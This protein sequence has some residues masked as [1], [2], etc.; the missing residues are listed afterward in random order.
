ML[1]ISGIGYKS[2]EVTPGNRTA[3]DVTLA[4]DA[5]VL[6]EVIVTGYTTDSW[7]DNTGAVGTVK[8]KDLTAVPSGNVEQQLQ[9]RVAGVTVITNGQPGTSSI[10]RAR[11]FGAFGGNEP[12]YVVDGVP[13]GDVGFVNPNDVETTTV[14]KDAASASI[15]GARAANGVIVMT[16]N[17][18][19]RKGQGITV[20]YDGLAGFTDPGVAPTAHTTITT[21]TGFST[22]T[23][24]TALTSAMAKGR[25]IT[26][27]GRLPTRRST[28]KRLVGTPLTCWGVFKH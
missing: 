28:A 7:R 4:E 20:T 13:T 5:S 3:V 11:G 8:A 12:L 14:L 15:C 19:T 27:R 2:Q 1:I 25:A 24:R 21:T 26:C 17:K 22:K 10:V 23:R 18:G 9:G 6:N 16:T